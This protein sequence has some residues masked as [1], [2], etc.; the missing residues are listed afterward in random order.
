MRVIMEVLK[1][2]RKEATSILE[3]ISFLTNARDRHDVR[4]AA[5][6][7]ESKKRSLDMK[8]L[9]KIQ[10]PGADRRI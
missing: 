1:D 9:S 10:M 3:L 4:A 7:L 2:P 6:E 5:M 8:S